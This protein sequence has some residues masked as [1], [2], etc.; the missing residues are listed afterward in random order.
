MTYR[1]VML[2]VLVLATGIIATELRPPRHPAL[3]VPTPEDEVAFQANRRVLET[4]IPE[5][6][7]RDTTVGPAIDRIRQAA[8]LG[9]AVNWQGLE[10]LRDRKVDIVLRNVAVGDAI[11]FVLCLDQYDVS[12]MP[13][14]QAEFDIVSGTLILGAPRILMQRDP[15]QFPERLLRVR[16]YDV[17]DLL[18]DEYW[19]Y[20]STASQTRAHEDARLHEVVG[21]VRQY[22]GMKNWAIETRSA[23]TH[24]SIM[25]LTSEPD[26]SAALNGFAG[27]LIAVQTTYG[28]MQIE[29]FLARLRA[30]HQG[31]P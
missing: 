15:N 25:S 27:R 7:L 9:L 16:V 3:P 23:G 8:R 30:M 19:G 20:A 29:A 10:D 5:L 26:G 14:P 6:D 13:I 22:A 1:N 18:T 17:R 2:T 21:L 28:H 31:K 4:R 12:Y 11:Q 24:S